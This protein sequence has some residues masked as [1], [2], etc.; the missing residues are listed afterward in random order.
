MLM[1]FCSSIFLGNYVFILYVYTFFFFL[2]TL[3][4]MSLFLS[5]SNSYN[6]KSPQ[7]SMFS[8]KH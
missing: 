3:E 7:T 2:R 5:H 1:T 6:K 4:E 8:E